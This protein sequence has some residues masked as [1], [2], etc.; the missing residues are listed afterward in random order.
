[1]IKQTGFFRNK[2]S[3][4]IGLGNALV[5]RYDGQVPGKMVDLVT[6]PGVGRKT[7]NVV[8]GNAFGIPGITVDTHVGRL[9]RRWRLTA[10]EDPVKVEQAIGGLIPAQRLDHVLAPHD[11]SWAPRLPRSQARLRRLHAGED[12]P[13]VRH[14]RDR[15]ES[16]GEAAEGPRQGVAEM[17]GVPE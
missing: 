1:M 3:S 13:V 2:T 14:R 8:L 15:S 17:A 9:V 12:V 16:R 4:L 5:E 10:E 7:A 11:L 6:L